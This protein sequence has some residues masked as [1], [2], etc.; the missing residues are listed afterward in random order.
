[1]VESSDYGTS[2]PSKESVLSTLVHRA[3]SMP[4]Q[5]PQAIRLGRGQVFKIAEAIKDAADELEA[6]FQCRGFLSVCLSSAPQSK[7][8]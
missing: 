7:H 5:R 2:R 1:M 8:S 3:V 4:L 6:A